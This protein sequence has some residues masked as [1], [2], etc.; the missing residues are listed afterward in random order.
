MISVVV[1]VYNEEEIIPLLH[2]AVVKAMSEI[3]DRWEVVYV[4]DGSKDSSLS[5]LRNLQLND[6][7]IVIVDLSRN[8]GHMGAISAGLQT[9]NGDAVVLM[10]GDLQDPPAVIPDFVDAWHKGAQV[11]TAVRRSR[12]ERRKALALLFPLFYRVLGA[13]SDFPI[14]LNAGIFGL[15]DRQAVDAINALREGN[16]Y[17]PGLRAWVGYR[18]AIVY[19][20]RHDRVGGDGKLSFVSR[21]KYAMDAITSFSYK[22][23]RLSFVLAGLAMFVSLIL[24][25]GALASSGLIQSIAFGITA[26]VFLVGS[27][28]LLSAGILGEYLG[29]VYDEVRQRPLSIISKV[30]EAD[31]VYEIVPDR[32]LPVNANGQGDHRKGVISRSA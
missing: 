5:L 28:V 19:Y 23:L 9:A 8:W 11:V 26:A 10:D 2:D 20:D 24:T 17:L 22:P 18:T 31:A 3:E 16:R 6:R 7:H 12:Q 30:Y 13:L 27:F 1:P 32:A 25:I 29:R 15:L 14:P 4:N 21:I